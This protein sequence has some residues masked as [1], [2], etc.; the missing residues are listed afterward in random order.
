MVS[1][2][3]KDSDLQGDVGRQRIR[4]LKRP[5]RWLCA[6]ERESD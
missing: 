5:L 4:R 2:V 1:A 6:K 3:V